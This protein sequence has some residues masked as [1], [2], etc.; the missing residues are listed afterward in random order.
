MKGGRSM[1]SIIIK[2]IS[3]GLELLGVF[4]LNNVEVQT[5]IGIAYIML[6]CVQLGYMLGS[7]Q[8]S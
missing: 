1:F 3:I 6:L 4:A 8:A 2:V 5:F 7:I